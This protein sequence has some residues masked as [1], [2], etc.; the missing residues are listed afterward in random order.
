MKTKLFI[1]ALLF[2]FFS[3]SKNEMDLAKAKET[4]ENCLNTIAKEDYTKVRNEY[5]SND[6]GGAEPAEELDSKFKK[7][8]EVTGDLQSFELKESS[9]SAEMGEETK[10]VLTYSVKHARVTTIEKFTIIIENGKY[11]IAGHDI[12]NE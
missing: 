1:V 9:I 10:A 2:T 8:K 6:L 11:K 4:A 12:K 3:C 7:L 5:Y